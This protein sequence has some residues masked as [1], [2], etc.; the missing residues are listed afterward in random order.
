M[1]IIGAL[2][3]EG[4]SR[5]KVEKLSLVGMDEYDVLIKN[6]AAGL[7]ASDLGQL[8]GTK[9]GVKF[10]LLSGHEGSGVVLD[11]GKSVSNIKPG[12]HVATCALGECGNCSNC[13]SSNTNLCENR[14]F[15]GLAAA[16]QYS[17][18][19]QFDGKPIALTSPGAS[20]ASHTICNEAHV[21]VLPK[22][23]PVY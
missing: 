7:C 6:R 18:H 3:I 8:S 5:L 23:V 22:E 17:E 2:A 12:D 20:F 9:E 21:A 4:N 11:V 14:G 16:Y 1:D 15:Q 13:H 10:P 19:F